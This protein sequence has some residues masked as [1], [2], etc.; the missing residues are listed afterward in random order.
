MLPYGRHWLDEDDIEAVVGVLRSGWLTGGPN[1]AL[2]EEEFARQVGAKCAVAVSNGTAALHGAMAAIGTGPGDEVIIPALTFAAS[3]NCARFVGA[4]VVFADVR[5]DSLTLNPESVEA[6]VTPR[7]RAIIAVD[8][9]GQPCDLEELNA[10]AARHGLTLIEDSS[11]ALGAMYCGRPVGGLARLT[12]FSLHPVKLITTGE[13]GVVT[14]DDAEMAARL[15]RFRNHGISADFRERQATGSWTYEMLE[16]GYNYRLTDFQCALGRSQL[17]KLAAWIERRR[18]IAARYT[19]AFGGVREVEVPLVLPNRSSA[20]HLYVVRLNLE[21]LLVGRGEI[22]RALRAENIGAAVHYI[23]VPWHPYYQK[24]GY[25]KGGWPVSET[26]YQRL[27]SLPIFPAMTDAD[28]NDVIAAF[29][30]VLQAYS[31]RD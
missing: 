7:T 30:K 1:V 23:P 18:A 8:F 25:T 28:V 10:I 12:T 4:T 26:A 29:A 2:F 3:A 13:G 16:L 22:L 15:R 17:K 6:A 14:T 20:W 27:I 19:H 5:P 31:K 21:R 24:L 11:H 9:A